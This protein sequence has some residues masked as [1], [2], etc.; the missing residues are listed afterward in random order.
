MV[1]LE[2]KQSQQQQ[3]R[4]VLLTFADVCAEQCLQPI[5]NPLTILA[6]VCEN[7]KTLQINGVKTV[8]NESSKDCN[9]SIHSTARLQKKIEIVVF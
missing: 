5:P 8:L 4:D 7:S 9:Q 6:N 3:T 2:R 1:I